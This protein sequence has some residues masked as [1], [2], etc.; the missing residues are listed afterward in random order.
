MTKKRD[1]RYIA[2]SLLVAI[3]NLTTLSAP[4][5][6]FPFGAINLSGCEAL[7]AHDYPRAIAE[8]LADSITPDS[9]YNLFKLGLAYDG[10]GEPTRALSVLRRAMNADS[11][12]SPMACEKIGDIASRERQFQNALVAYRTAA[13]HIREQR[14]QYY[15]YGK[16]HKLIEEHRDSI[17]AVPWLD[18]IIASLAEPKGIDTLDALLKKSIDSCRWTT[19][20][21]LL[22]LVLGQTTAE[23]CCPACASVHAKELPDSVLSTGTV[24]RLARNSMACGN[25]PAASDWLNRAAQRTD[26][27]RTV[28]SKEFLYCRAELNYRLRNY[29]KAISWFKKYIENYPLTPDLVYMMARSYRSL[30]NGALAEEWYN[31]HLQLFPNHPKTIDILWYRAWIFEDTGNYPA[32]RQLYQ[33]ISVHHKSSARAAEAQFRSALC[34][35]KEKNYLSAQKSFAKCIRTFPQSLQIGAARYWKAKCLLARHQKDDAYI[36]LQ[37]L[38]RS[39]PTGYYGF[40]A[41]EQL[42]ISGDS[43]VALGI[44]TLSDIAATLRRLDSLSDPSQA[45]IDSVTY[46]RGLLL[47]AAGL[48]R[49]ADMFLEPLEYRYQRNMSLQFTLAMLYA[50]SGDPT[51][52]YRIA[53]QLSWRIPQESRRAMPLVLYKLFYPYAFG[54][55]VADNSRQRGISPALVWAVMRQESTFDPA[56]VSPAGAVGL[57]QIMPYTGREI[58]QALSEQFAPESLYVPEINIRYGV[59][60]ISKLLADFEGNLPL[61]IASYNGGP[62]NA[63]RWLAIN[64]DDEFDVFIEDIGFAETRDYVKKVLANY[65]TYTRLSSRPGSGFDAVN[66]TVPPLQSDR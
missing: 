28:S 31:R 36:E 17:G 8:I 20:D 65:W 7:R 52:S 26:L 40:R 56:I 50:W 45:E 35:Y 23:K 54:E 42:L 59:W 39:D 47:S 3:A 24:F 53:R 61:A 66:G 18:E 1:L 4:D 32:A 22:S 12:I 19:A 11:L 57:M 21:S 2:F 38:S 64:K 13:D 33:R 55:R 37:A 49:H 25:N 41:R 14:Y 46:N 15:L 44:D 63:R 51:L 27:G 29:L 9:G 16:M 30:G 62:H 5:R 10:L 43:G 48:T 34:Y 58:A 6:L 60:Y